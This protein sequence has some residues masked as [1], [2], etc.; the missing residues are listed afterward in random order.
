MVCTHGS[1]LHMQYSV[2][3]AQSDH[4]LIVASFL[5]IGD[6]KTGA[7]SAMSQSGFVLQSDLSKRMHGLDSEDACPQ[8]SFGPVPAVSGRR[9]TGNH[10]PLSRSKQAQL[11]LNTASSAS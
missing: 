4:A 5:R 2:R 11:S 6:G 9:S 8:M 3:S 1:I 10:W 7:T